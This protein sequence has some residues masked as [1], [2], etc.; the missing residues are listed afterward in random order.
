MRIWRN[1][2]LEKVA[3]VRTV[4]AVV[5]LVPLAGCNFAFLLF[6]HEEG[7]SGV[8]VAPLVGRLGVR[9]DWIHRMIEVRKREAVEATSE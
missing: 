4:A 1:P 2:R 5:P 8:A 3:A 6:S 9:W 7:V